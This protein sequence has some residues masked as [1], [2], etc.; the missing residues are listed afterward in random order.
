[1]AE[2]ESTFNLA[3]LLRIP[4]QALVEELHARQEDTTFGDIRPA[5]TIIFALV[6]A[7]GMRISELTARAQ[8]TKQVMN[9]L[10]NTVE[11]NG[12][13]ERIPDPTDGRSKIVRLTE[14]GLQASRTGRQIIF[15]I[16]S[17]WTEKFGEEE[18]RQLRSLLERLVGIL[19]ER[20][21]SHTPLEDE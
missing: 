21:A 2:G 4:F 15:D 14:R 11:K 9:Y 8:T 19:L 10:L 20:E 6:G 12:Y 13:I 16:E 17:E 7:E 18:M 1:M 3:A 5:H